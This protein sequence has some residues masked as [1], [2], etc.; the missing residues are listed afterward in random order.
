MSIGSVPFGNIDGS[1]SSWL[2]RLRQDVNRPKRP[3]YIPVTQF[4]GLLNDASL[5]TGTPALGQVNSLGLV[6]LRI[7]A[8]TDA[9]NHLFYVPKDFN[10]DTNIKFSVVWTTNSVDTAET[11][12]WKVQ[13]NAITAGQALAAASSELDTVIS[14]DNVLGSYVISESPE[15]ILSGG[16]WYHGDYV[17]L[18]VSLSAVSGLDPATD[19]VFLLGLLITDE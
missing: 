12:T 18:K 4:S 9:I 13:Y 10:V 7:D 8:A 14:E 17:N 1:L 15:G 19:I 16:N 6:G 3:I 2:E 11:A 5:S